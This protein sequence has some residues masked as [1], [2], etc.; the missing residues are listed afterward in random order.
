VKVVVYGLY[1][2]GPDAHTTPAAGNTG[3][4]EL[5]TAW[6]ED[7]GLPRLRAAFNGTAIVEGH[8]TNNEPKDNLPKRK[9][10]RRGGV[11]ARHTSD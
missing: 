9:K 5:T 4:V 8:A 7:V 6:L 11:K 3:L 10:D 2:V 1:A